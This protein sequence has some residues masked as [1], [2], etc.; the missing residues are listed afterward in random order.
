MVGEAYSSKFSAWLA[1]GC[2]SPRTIYKEIRAYERKMGPMIL[3]I[4]DFELLWRDFF[5]F[6]FKNTRLNFF[7]CGYKG[8]K[9]TH[10]L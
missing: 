4:G 9:K 8:E 3:R 5:R 7:I 10:N 6:M 1:M 2:I